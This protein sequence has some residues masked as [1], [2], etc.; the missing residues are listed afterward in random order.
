MQD[1]DDWIKMTEKRISYLDEAKRKRALSYEEWTAEKGK[2]EDD[3]WPTEEER[4][5]I[6]AQGAFAF[7]ERLGLFDRHQK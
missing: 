3:P 1:L 6:R 2:S 4:M 5:R 7:M